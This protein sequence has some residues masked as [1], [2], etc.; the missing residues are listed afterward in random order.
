MK[1]ISNPLQHQYF[2]AALGIASAV[3]VLTVGS[4][5]VLPVVLSLLLLAGGVGLGS[6]SARREA[7]L[8]QAVAA[9][10]AGQASFGAE[11]VPV[12]RGHIEASREQMESAINTLSERFGD[13]VDKLGQAL[14][15]ASLE[16]QKIDV[17]NGDKGL[18]AVFERSRVELDAVISA[19]QETMGSM[20]TMLDKVQGLDVFITELQEMAFDVAKIA[21]Q[22]TLLSLNAAIEAARAGEQ[23]RGFAVVAK[24]FRMLSTQSG[25]TGRHIAEKVSV[26]SAAIVETC[27]V[28]REAVNLRDQRSHHTQHVIGRMLGEFKEITD[29]LQHSSTLLKVE[30]QCIQQNIG[31]ALV[32][33]QFQDRV[34]QIMTQV[35]KNIERLPIVLQEQQQLYAQTGA[36]LPPDPQ[37][38]LDEMKKTYVMADQHIIHEGGQVAAKAADTDISFF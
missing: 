20:L 4:F 7:T 13:I 37:D 3:A 23:G 27:K 36:L 5:D 34:S 6:Q 32:Q 22:S 10:L 24:E 8:R 17:D 38:M 2:P 12:W 19:Q 9:Y 25:N 14:Q 26:I 11:V 30:S 16:T 33:M 28:V 1:L 18:V 29:A 21:Q 35:I 31:E 15:T